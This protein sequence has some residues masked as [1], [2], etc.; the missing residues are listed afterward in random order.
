MPCLLDTR[1]GTKFTM[2]EFTRGVGGFELLLCV[3]AW[4]SE[5]RFKNFSNCTRGTPSFSTQ[6]FSAHAAPPLCSASYLYRTAC[7]RRSGIWRASSRVQRPAWPAHLPVAGKRS[8]RW[9]RRSTTAS[10][11]NSDL[12]APRARTVGLS[13]PSGS[14]VRGR[15]AHG[16]RPLRAARSSA[17]PVRL[18]PCLDDGGLIEE[19]MRCR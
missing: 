10:G 14:A 13:V 6:R 7:A 4:A 12:R 17:L 5:Q 3:L 1:S 11:S 19:T 16:D 15:R 9:R 8:A 18:R 2:L